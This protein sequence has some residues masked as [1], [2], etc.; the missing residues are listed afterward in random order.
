[1]NSVKLFD[2]FYFQILKAEASLGAA[3]DVRVI[4]KGSYFLSP[5][6]VNF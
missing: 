6:E 3:S 5:V 4:E 1:V 2:I